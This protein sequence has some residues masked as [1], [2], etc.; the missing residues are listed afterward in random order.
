MKFDGR[1][2]RRLI[3]ANGHQPRSVKI[4]R[5]TLFVTSA[6]IG[7]LALPAAAHAQSWVGGITAPIP[8]A[9]SND[10]N[11]AANWS[12][13][14][15]PGLNDVAVFGPSN[16]T[17]LTLTLFDNEVQSWNFTSTTDYTFNIVHPIVNLPPLG[18]VPFLLGFNGDGITGNSSHVTFNNL[19]GLVL[20][21]NSS[22]AGQA[23]FNNPSSIWFRD[24]STAANATFNN[25]HEIDFFDSSTAGNATFKNTVRPGDV[26]ST[27][28]RDQSTAGNATIIIKDDGVGGAFFR[29]ASTAGHATITNSGGGIAFGNTATA[30]QATITNDGATSIIAFLDTATA[31]QAIFLNVNGGD[32]F[33]GFFAGDSPTAGNATIISDATSTIRFFETSTAG[34]ATIATSGT[35]QFFEN[36]TAGSATIA[37]G[38]TMS[39]LAKSTGGNATITNGAAAVTDFSASSGPNGDHKLSAGSIAG[40]G[41]FALGQ[42]ELTVGGNNLSTAVS[43]V[44]ADGG[45]GGGTGASLV[46]RGTGTLTLSGNNTY[47]GGTSIN[48]GTVEISADSNLG[49]ASGNLAFAGGTLRFLADVTTNRAVTLNASGGIVDTNGNNATLAS[50]VSGAG[51]LTKTGTGTLTLGGTNTYGGGTTINGGTLAISADN[52][53][54]AAGGNLAFDGGTLR[55]LAD[56]T[57]NRAVTLNAGGGTFDTNGNNATLA[58]TVSGAGGLTK[59]G[60]GTLTLGGTNIYGGGT[61]INGGTLAISADNNFGDASGNLA[62]DGGTLRLLLGVTTNRAVTLNAGGGIVDTNGNNAT[63]ASTVSGAGGLTKTGIGRLTLEA[64]NT[65]TGA[66]TVNGGTLAGDVANAFSAVSAIAINSGGTLDLGGFAQTVNTINLAG[67][68][69]ANGSLTGA[70]NSTGGTITGLGG[71]ASLT[72]TA[73]TTTLD[74]SNTYSGATAISG[75]TLAAGAANAFSAVSAIAINSG[76]T[77]DLGG[78]AQTVNTINLA[79]GTLANGTLTGAIQ[80]IGGTIT[81]LGGSA[82]LTTTAGTTTLDVS[83]TYSGAT[84]INGGTLAGGAAN[85]FSA[86]S[87]IAINSGGTL[88]LGGFAQTINTI[89]LAGGTLANGTLTGAVNSTGGTISGLGGSARLTTT[90]GTTTLDGGNTYTGPTSVNGGALIVNG[91]IASAATVN[92]GGIL[93]GVGSIFNDVAVNSGGILAPGNTTVGTSLTVGAISPCNPARN[94][95]CSFRR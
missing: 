50:T 6:L 25:T 22:T 47:S 46:K 82:S 24:N 40:G 37:N 77:L 58:S 4:W 10:Y 60:T 14:H 33:F 15:F 68:T 66:T 92:S 29:D 85:A 42:N 17:D 39:F 12:P 61:A 51:G 48:G 93:G 28:F 89:N 32:I 70:V 65:Y 91:S 57:T 41:L 73:G 9:T 45:A 1:R 18:F 63:F 11:N 13:G 34:S 7:S 94:I 64:N 35:T 67:G 88:D 87:V 74:G 78:F 53:L 95:L 31:G 81:G 56:V 16:N 79:G 30:G 86:V 26:G 59:T 83:N 62:F 21:A 8:S 76:G 38:G 20:F 55:F 54:G 23:T 43:G 44:I 3:G 49:A 2:E 69:L 71:S 5:K 80:S 52:N 72:T 75:G 19:T 90:A 36:S 84:A 27:I